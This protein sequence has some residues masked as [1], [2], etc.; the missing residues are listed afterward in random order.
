MGRKA[1]GS[2]RDSRVAEISQIDMRHSAVFISDILS[3]IIMSAVVPPVTYTVTPVNTAHG[4]ISPVTQQVLNSGAI[5]DFTVTPDIGYQID[6]VTGFGCSVLLLPNPP[7]AIY[8]AG[9]VAANCTGAMMSPMRPARGTRSD[10][11]QHHF[12][13][14]LNFP[15]FTVIVGYHFIGDTH[16]CG[17]VRDVAETVGRSGE[18][19]GRRRSQPG[20]FFECLRGFCARKLDEAEKRVELLLKQKDGSFI[21]EEFKEQG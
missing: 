4:S 8:R 15:P 13:P 2:H 18:K 1:Y 14:F 11:F 3:T 10:T 21:R 7:P 12:K 19:A 17:K 9:P 16:G 5:V 6:T 20:G